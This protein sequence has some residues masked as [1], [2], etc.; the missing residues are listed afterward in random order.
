MINSNEDDR[1]TMRSKTF[2]PRPAIEAGFT[3]I[4]L[5]IVVAIIGILASLAIAAYETYTVR[6]QVAEGLNMAAG[7][8]VPIVDAFTNSGQAPVDRVAAGMSPNPADTR[9]QF[10]SQVDIN[11]GRIEITFG[12]TRGH[13]SIVGRILYVTPIL[14][15]GNTVSWQCGNAGAPPGAILPGGIAHIAPTV[16]T[17]YLPGECR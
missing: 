12:G 6:A 17:R 7:A 5:M 4:E 16:D 15:A 10:V 1:S 8:K 14:A 3:L 9:G 13:Q 11:Q 2:S